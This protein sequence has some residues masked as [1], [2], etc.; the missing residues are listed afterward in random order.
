MYNGKTNWKHIVRPALLWFSQN[1]YINNRWFYV[2]LRNFS[3]SW[4]HIVFIVL[5]DLQVRFCCFRICFC[6]CVIWFYNRFIQ[7]FLGLCVLLCLFCILYSCFLIVLL[8]WFVL[9][10]VLFF[11]LYKYVSC[12]VLY[13]L[14]CFNWFSM[15]RVSFFVPFYLLF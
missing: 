4:N 3:V 9:Y 2:F 6:L 13:L 12:C 7:S 14:I 10:S 15:M 11:F 5:G 1:I 8:K